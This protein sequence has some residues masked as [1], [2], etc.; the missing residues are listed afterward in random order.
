M[1]AGGPDRR[2][3]QCLDRPDAKP[4]LAG[5][6]VGGATTLTRV[7][8]RTVPGPPPCARD[9]A[10]S[11]QSGRMERSEPAP[12]KAVEGGGGDGG[13]GNNMLTAISRP[14]MR[15]PSSR[16]LWPAAANPERGGSTGS[17]PLPGGCLLYVVRYGIQ[18]AAG[19]QVFS[20]EYHGWSACSF[21]FYGWPPYGVDLA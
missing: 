14:H 5:R 19:G 13:G 12:T 4:R 15:Y 7:F 17:D 10:Y 3:G 21:F 16:P 11:R 9:G 1:P 20:R 2:A 18:D 8:V 6:G